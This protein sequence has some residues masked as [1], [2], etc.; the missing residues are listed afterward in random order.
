MNAQTIRAFGQSF[1]GWRPTT[2]DIA[3]VYNPLIYAWQAHEAYLERALWDRPQGRVLWLGINPGPWGMAQTATPFGDVAS[4]RDWMGVGPVEVGQP[5]DPSPLRPIEGFS[6]TRREVSGQRLW[7]WAAGRFGAADACFD[8]MFVWN[9]CPLMFL[10][11][12]RAR[13][14]TPDRLNAADQAAILPPCDDMLRA[15]VA[16][17]QPSHVLGVGRFTTARATAALATLP[18]PPPVH[19]MLHPSPASPAANR[20]WAAQ[21]DARLVELGIWC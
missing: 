21:A 2:P 4:V 19:Y 18:D 17:I 10:H 20:G 16:H 1:E 3:H 15:L 12:Q 11:A 14:V 13:N 9:F 6:L 5:A 8:A 7:A